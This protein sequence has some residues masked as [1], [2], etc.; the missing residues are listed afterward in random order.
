[1]KF[2][3]AGSQCQPLANRPQPANV[4]LIG[5]VDDDT[6]GRALERGRC[7]AEPGC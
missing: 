7:H 5:V 2:V 4:G 1:V 3:L 6:P